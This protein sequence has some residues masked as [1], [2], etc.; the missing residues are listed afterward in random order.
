V[1]DAL[2][3][4]WPVCHVRVHPM[5]TAKTVGQCNVQD[6]DVAPWCSDNGLV[7]VTIDAGFATRWVK[8]G[9][10]ANHGVEVIVFAKDIKG[11][12][13]QHEAITRHLPHWME[14]LGKVTYGFRVWEQTTK[15]EPS[16]KIGKKKLLSSS[17]STSQRRRSARS[18]NATRE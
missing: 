4:F 8:S 13:A 12:R 6:Q 10:L 5:N 18:P 9:L 2:A 16:L 3:P 15:L 14:T 7:L 1:A 17:A 11:P